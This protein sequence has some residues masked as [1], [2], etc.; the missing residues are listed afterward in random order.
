MTFIDTKARKRPPRWRRR[1]LTEKP[2]ESGTQK[3]LFLA[4][5]SFDYC[6]LLV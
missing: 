4:K 6:K 2:H 1:Q 5:L 3:A